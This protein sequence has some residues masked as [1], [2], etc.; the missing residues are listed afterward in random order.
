LSDSNL[1]VR[2]LS[3]VAL[4]AMGTAAEKAIPGLVK[5]LDDPSPSVRAVAADALGNLGPAGKPAVETLSRH[6]I[7]V[8]EPVVFVMRSLASALG[9]I[10]PTAASALPALEQAAKI[11]R[12]SW[13][14]EEAIL[15]IKGEPV[16]VWY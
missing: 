14:A 7:G 9:N 11:H 1:R 5:A 8:N 2:S 3:A 16:P 10:G 12:V 15:K 6:L 13:A 4:R